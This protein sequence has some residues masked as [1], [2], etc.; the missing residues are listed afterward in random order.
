MTE[1]PAPLMSPDQATWVRENVW[2][3]LRLRNHNHIPSTTFAC[4]CQKPPSVECQRDWHTSC[5]H[6]GHAINETVISTSS[7]RAARFPD[8]YEHSSPVRSGRNDLAWVWLAGRPCR[9]ICGCVCH[10]PAP[11]PVKKPPVKTVQAAEPL[12]LF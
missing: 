6:D 11:D 7:Q 12:C 8:P 10:R 4:A 2:S 3:A 5:R 9:E 1:R